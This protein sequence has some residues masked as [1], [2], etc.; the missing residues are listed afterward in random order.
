MSY[1]VVYAGR[2][3]AKNFSLE[4]GLSSCDRET[5]HNLDCNAYCLDDRNKMDGSKTFRIMSK[6]RSTT[7]AILS[8][9]TTT[10]TIKES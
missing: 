7:R 5:S 9:E 10:G 8:S 4:M 2:N 6:R 1:T 3:F